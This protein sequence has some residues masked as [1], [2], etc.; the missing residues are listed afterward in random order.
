MLIAIVF[1]EVVMR[2]SDK[3]SVHGYSGTNLG[4]YSEAGDTEWQAVLM[5]F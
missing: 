4:A 2:T 5:Y 1:A 3:N